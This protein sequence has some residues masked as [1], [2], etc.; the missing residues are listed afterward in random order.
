[1]VIDYDRKKEGIDCGD[2]YMSYK[3]IFQD[4]RAAVDWVHLN[5][6][7][8]ITSSALFVFIRCSE[9]SHFIVL[10]EFKYRLFLSQLKNDLLM[11]MV[12]LCKQLTGFVWFSAVLV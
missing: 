5:V 2:I 12:R 3:S 1:M 6:S 7:Y 10:E 9:A 11:L 8:L 4:V